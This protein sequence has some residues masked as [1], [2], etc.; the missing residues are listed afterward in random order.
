MLMQWEFLAK[1]F[2]LKG[3]PFEKMMTKFME[4]VSNSLY[5]AVAERNVS[6]FPFGEIFQA[7]KK[8]RHYRTAKYSKDLT[9]QQKNRSSGNMPEGKIYYSSKDKLY[10]FKVKV[11]VLPI[12]QAI[13]FT[14]H[15]PVSVADL[16]TFPRNIDIYRAALKNS[17]L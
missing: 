12:G 1:A 17:R 7:G 10:W 4:I 15:Y 2:S 11:T 9:F 5:E 16:E 13:K 3:R 14:P 6:L 8:F